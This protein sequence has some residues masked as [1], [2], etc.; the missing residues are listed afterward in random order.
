MVRGLS[1]LSATLSGGAKPDKAE[2]P[3]ARQRWTRAFFMFCQGRRAACFAEAK[4]QSGRSTLSVPICALFL[5]R[6]PCSNSADGFEVQLEGCTTA[7]RLLPGED[8][9]FQGDLY[10][11][12]SRAPEKV[13]PRLNRAGRRIICHLPDRRVLQGRVRRL[14]I[15]E[16]RARTR[17]PATHHY[18]ERELGKRVAK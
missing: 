3:F 6:K 1:K 16:A 4:R 13:G 12:V 10:R 9:L 11:L 2:F 14:L 18:A 17:K 7:T 15:L 5:R 8:I